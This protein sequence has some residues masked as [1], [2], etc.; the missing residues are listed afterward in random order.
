MLITTIG[1]SVI[2]YNIQLDTPI[3]ILNGHNSTV[4]NASFSPDDKYIITTSTDST[5]KIWDANNAQLIYTLREQK[6]YISFASF[7][8]DGNY[9]LTTSGSSTKLRDSKNYKERGNFSCHH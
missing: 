3:L 8:D 4:F 6:K 7:S 9:I 1:E 5:S 2:L